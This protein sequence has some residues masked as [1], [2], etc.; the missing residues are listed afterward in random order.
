MKLSKFLFLLLFILSASVAFAQSSSELKR[1]KEAIQREIELLQRNL[2]KTANNKKLTLSQINALNAKIKLM[3]DKITVINSEIKNLDNQIHENTNTVIILK[4]QLGQLKK[5]YAGMIRFAQRNKNAYDKMMFVFAA[6]DFNQAY[7]RIKYL[8]QF[9]QYRKK[10]AGYIQGTQKDLNYKI[11]ILDKN[12]KEKSNLLHE[13]ENEKDKLGKNKTEQSAVLNRYSKEEKQFRQDIATRKK[14]QAQLDRSI[15]AAIVREIELERKRAEEAARVAAAKA[16]RAA[17]IAA[18]AA[19]AKAKAENKPA[20][21]AP[22]PV[23]AAKPKASNSEYL[24]ATPEAAKLSAAFESN[25][26][27]LPWPVASGSITESFG[28][29]KEGQAS[30]DNAGVT[31]QTAD[32]AGVRAVFNG[33]VTKVGNALGRYYVLIK[34]GQFF[35]VYQNLRTVSVSAGD[36]VSTKQNIGTVASSGDMPELQFQIYRGAVA[37]NPAS[38]IAK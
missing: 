34:H 12:L 38:W 4:G 5:D 17:S 27:S 21:P 15:R 29:H 31:I 18:A 28:K 9:G 22:A 36:D 16:A 20:P 8:Q 23:A 2:N 37:Q 1:K 3:Q 19:A 30:Y 25:R 10:Q 32:G 7:K 14:Q 33:K 35:T 6:K 24:A 13:Q 26:G 11:V